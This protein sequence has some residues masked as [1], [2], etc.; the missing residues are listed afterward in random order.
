MARTVLNAKIGVSVSGTGQS[1]SSE[2]QSMTAL[3][4]GSVRRGLLLPT[5]VA[6]E[7]VGSRPFPFRPVSG[8]PTDCSSSLPRGRAR[9]M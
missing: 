9:M 6:L 1:G 5:T 8:L 3:T 4:V 7:S 2:Q